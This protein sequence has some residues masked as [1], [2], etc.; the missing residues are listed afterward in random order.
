MIKENLSAI[1]NRINAAASKAG[2]NSDEITLIA[3]SK[4]KSVEMIQEAIAAGQKDFGEN[5]LQEAKEKITTLAGQARF[6][7]I[8]SLQSNKAK[9]AAT[10][11]DMIHTVDRLKLARALDKYAGAAGKTLAILIQVNVGREEQKAGVLPEDAQEL[12]KQMQDLDHL[13]IKGLMTMPPY[14]TNP[15]DVRPY[16]AELR[17][18]GKQ[19]QKDGLIATNCPLQL[20]MGM[21]GDFEAAIAEGATMIRVGT[22]I[23]G[24]R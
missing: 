2:R 13:E 6:H 11:C 19:L 14:R 5:Y 20:S 4:R 12:I 17:E 10:L 7:F 15:E 23:F 16:F 24:E 8:G 9:D 18:L 21:S 3:V 22:A 1:H